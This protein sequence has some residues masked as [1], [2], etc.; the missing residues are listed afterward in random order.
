MTEQEFGLAAIDDIIKDSVTGREHLNVRW[1]SFTDRFITAIKTAKVYIDCGAEYGFYVSLALKY[2]PRDLKI[3]AF[4]PEP[5]RFNLLESWMQSYPNVKI[6]RLAI[7]DHASRREVVKPGVGV[8]LSLEGC[9]HDTG[10]RFIVNSVS[11]D[12]I[13]SEVNV[14][15]I[16]MDIE[17][18]EDL[19]F[20]G[21]AQVLKHKPKLFIEWHPP[22]Y[23]IARITTVRNLYTAGYKNIRV[24]SSQCG[25]V[26]LE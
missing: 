10:S 9:F 18:A 4:E 1:E 19:A 16:K 5:M 17:G 7:S 21:M 20:K 15:I 11:L 12:D 26:V 14:D 24:E 13:L 6:H 22:A 23:D 25:R 2:G 8:S 3:I